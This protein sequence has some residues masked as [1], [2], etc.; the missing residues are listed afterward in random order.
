VIL[1]PDKRQAGTA[2]EKT[3][4]NV[5]FPVRYVRYTSEE[6]LVRNDENK[7][8][9]EENEADKA[10]LEEFARFVASRGGRLDLTS[11]AGFGCFKDKHPA[12]AYSGDV[13]FFTYSHSNSN[14]QLNHPLFLSGK[15]TTSIIS[16]LNIYCLSFVY[17]NY[18]DLGPH[19]SMICIPS[20]C[21]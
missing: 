6:Q 18:C 21:Q 9:W 15:C 2:T 14:M 16:S 10:K 17:S 19:L 5:F 11:V 12:Y 7:Y 1:F 4:E 13:H 3:V 20:V 8:L